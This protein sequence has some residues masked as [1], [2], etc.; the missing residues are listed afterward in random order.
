VS[1]GSTFTLAP[2]STGTDSG[3]GTNTTIADVGGFVGAEQIE[4]GD[5]VRNTASPFQFSIVTAIA[6]N[7]LTVTDNGLTWASLAYSVNTFV[8]NYTAGNNAYVPLIERIADVASES[9]SIIYL[10]DFDIKVVVRRTSSI[11]ILPF[12]QDTDFTA[13]GREVTTVRTTDTIIT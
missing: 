6:D 10:G 13:T 4:V 1:G 11:A 3:S 9:N 12:S 2:A 5:F 8:E 7:V